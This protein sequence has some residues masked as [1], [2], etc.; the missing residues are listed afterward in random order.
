MNTQQRVTYAHCLTHLGVNR[1][2]EFPTGIVIDNTVSS[3]DVKNFCA[4]VVDR[5]DITC[6]RCGENGH[7]KNECLQWRTRLCWHFMNAKCYKDCC[8]FAHGSAALRSPWNL[9]CVRI[10]KQGSSF[11]D[12]GC[13]SFEH[14]FRSCPFLKSDSAADSGALSDRFETLRLSGTCLPCGELSANEVP[15]AK[16][17]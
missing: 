11:T 3:V 9:K 10:I 8:P 14:S 16:N 1:Q 15:E 6:F 7:R 17:A 2:F 5:N 12:I 13:G 4:H